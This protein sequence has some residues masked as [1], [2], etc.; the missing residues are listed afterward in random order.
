MALLLK[1]IS[2][3]FLFSSCNSELVAAT[4]DEL[5]ASSPNSRGLRKTR[6]EPSVYV[7]LGGDGRCLGTSPTRPDTMTQMHRCNE[8]DPLQQF[9]IVQQGKYFHIKQRGSGQCLSVSKKAMRT[10]LLA[11][12]ECSDKAYSLWS[13]KSLGTKT[14]FNSASG[15]CLIRTRNSST[16]GNTKSHK[17][18]VM[19]STRCEGTR[20]TGSW[21]LTELDIDDADGDFGD[22]DDDFGGDDDFGDDDEE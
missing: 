2:L 19:S 3:I 6:L 7:T 12:H 11:I 13:M 21:E 17:P 15:L 20:F 10:G 16:T 1:L 5:T 9:A 18:K 22:D 4:R 14:V 8:D